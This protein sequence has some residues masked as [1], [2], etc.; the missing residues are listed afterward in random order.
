[1]RQHNKTKAH[2]GHVVCLQ[3]TP[4]RIVSGSRDKTVLMQDFWLDD[5]DHVKKKRTQTQE[6][7]KD[8]ERMLR[9]KAVL[10]R[11]TLYPSIRR[12]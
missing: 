11:S 1:M 7:T 5:A 3:L 8:Q 4:T 12:Y 2:K 10:D 9:R 6:L